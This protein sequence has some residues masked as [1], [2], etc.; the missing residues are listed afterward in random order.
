MD[1]EHAPH[2]SGMEEFGINV[3]WPLGNSDWKSL[4]DELKTKTAITRYALH[5]SS[6]P[7]FDFVLEFTNTEN[8][9]YHF[10]DTTG[11]SYGVNTFSRG[12]HL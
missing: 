12:D 4:S 3:D 6:H 8:Y 9:N 1:S 11:D 5:H 2:S 7:N 10:Y